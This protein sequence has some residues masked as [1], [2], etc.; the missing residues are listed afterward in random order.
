MAER[1]ARVRR[2]QVGFLF[3]L[4]VSFAQV[5]WWL[6]DQNAFVLESERRVLAGLERER[7]AVAELIAGG[8]DPDEIA[9]R[10][11]DLEVSGGDVRLRPEVRERLDR[12]RARR[13]NRYLWEGGFFLVVLGAGMAVLWR[14]LRQEAD[15]RRR[16]ENFL[17]AASHELKSPLASL[18]LHTET[19]VARTFDRDEQL[20]WLGR[21]LT[22]VGRLESLVGKLLESSR[23]DAGRVEL[24]CEPVDLGKVVDE[25]QALVGGAPST[26]PQRIAN[27]VPPDLE[28][29]ADPVAT[30]TIVR[31]LV[32]NAWKAT[33]GGGEV[34]VEGS[35]V[36]GWIELVVRDTGVGFDPAEARRLFDKF[37]RPGDELRRRSTGT[38]LGLYLVARL[39]E[40]EGG[41]VT[42]VSTGPG[43][44]AHFVARWPRR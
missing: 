33:A 44:G 27:R 40:L 38:G 36:D 24:A 5:L 32:E 31:N 18:R 1:V 25:A 13:R 16:Q 19:L 39:L 10:H 28:I 3:L 21:S 23:L 20:R 4:A 35:A 2:F 29:L 9:R 12:E 26:G 41:T 14:V 15:L 22:D 8:S 34:V 42:A 43:H 37:Y 17:A 30:A 6:I 7:A 11:R